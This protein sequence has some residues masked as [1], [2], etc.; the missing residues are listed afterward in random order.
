MFVCSLYMVRCI[1]NVL[2][3]FVFMFSRILLL[4]VYR[5]K[6]VRYLFCGVNSVV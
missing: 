1:F 6:F 3:R 4:L 2:V 5:K